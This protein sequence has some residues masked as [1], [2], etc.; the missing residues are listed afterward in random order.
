VLNETD[1][2]KEFLRL[3]DEA[4][5]KQKKFD[6]IEFLRKELGSNSE[7]TLGTKLLVLD[8]FETVSNP[9]ELFQWLDTYVRLPNK[10]L[11]TTRF[12]EFKAD[13]PIEVTGMTYEEFEQLAFATASDLGIRPL[14]SSTYLD[15]LFEESNGHPYVVKILL[16]EA[17]KTGKIDRV[18][19]IFATKDEILLALFERTY[20]GLSSAAKRIFLTLSNWRSTVPLIALEAVILR[21]ENDRMDVQKAVDELV[22]SSLVEITESEKDQSLF[23]SM[24]LS[25][26]IF[27]KKKLITSSIKAT[28]EA[29]TQ[30]LHDFGAGQTGDIKLGAE[31]RIRRLFS[32]LAKRIGT[33][34]HA[35]LQNYLPMLEFICRQ[36][37][38]AWLMLASFLEEQSE[39]ELAKE[40]IEKY[41]ESNT[42]FGKLEAWMRYERICERVGDNLGAINANVEIACLPNT[43]FFAISNCVNKFNQITYQEDLK[44]DQLEKRILIQKLIDAMEPK[45]AL[46]GD[47][48]DYSRLAWLYLHL[49]DF[50]KVEQLVTRGLELDPLNVHCLNLAMRIGKKIG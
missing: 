15:A 46:E 11:I 40:A 27:G 18:Q 24:P 4:A 5:L 38:P 42:E 10:I 12:R 29:D 2:A 23:L 35:S 34:D 39:L 20:S 22:Q 44:I 48:S 9:L 6:H 33:Q 37:S 25:S 7:D 26:A 43:S 14:I 1:I 49:Q 30:F 28:I 41:I 17:A 19:K 47:A 45:I 3:T 16:G 50:G 32:N 36:Y 31:P 13:F 21:N 8:N